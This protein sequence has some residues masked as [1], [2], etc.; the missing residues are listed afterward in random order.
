MVETPRSHG[1][2]PRGG[3]THPV[4]ISL[5]VADSTFCAYPRSSNTERW[6][7]AAGLGVGGPSSFEITSPWLADFGRLMACRTLS[8]AAAGAFSLGRAVGPAPAFCP[9]WT[10]SFAGLPRHP[11]SGRAAAA[12]SLAVGSGSLPGTRRRR[13]WVLRAY[14]CVLC[15]LKGFWSASQGMSSRAGD[16]RQ[17]CAS[18]LSLSLSRS[19]APPLPAIPPPQSSI[20]TTPSCSL[21][22]ILPEDQAQWLT[23]HR[24]VFENRPSKNSK[25]D[26]L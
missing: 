23:Q 26:S 12:S 2:Q 16:S 24:H 15:E 1:S 25:F 5:H 21:G 22:A 3:K 4:S 11:P 13:R 9:S 10:R 8:P 17:E 14:G 20:T 7:A 18:A 19:S 6:F